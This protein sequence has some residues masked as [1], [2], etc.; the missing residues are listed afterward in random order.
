MNENTLAIIVA[1]GRSSRLSGDGGLSRADRDIPKQY[2]LLAGRSV[3]DRTVEKFACHS[4]IDNILVV[5]HR[6]DVDAYQKLVSTHD[7]LLLSVT[8]GDSR[9]QSVHNGLIAAHKIGFGGKIL[10]HDAARPFVESDVITQVLDNIAPAI[11]AIAAHRVVDTLKRGDSRLEVSSTVARDDL[12]CAQTP[13]GFMAKDIIAVHDNASKNG[14]TDFTDDASMFEAAGLAVRIINASSLNFKIT[15]PDD[16]VRAR[17]LVEKLEGPTVTHADIRTGN[18]YDVHAFSPGDGVILCGYKIPFDKKLSGHSD[19]DVALHALT[20]AL[21]GTIGAGDIG[22]HFPPSEHRWKDASSDLFLKYALKLVA[23]EGGVINNVDITLI[24]EAPKIG[25]H[26]EKMRVKLAELCALE[27]ARVSVKATTNEK[28]G[29]LGREEGIA[30]IATV[31]I[32]FGA[33]S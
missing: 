11:G 2:M 24:C 1:G 33:R 20:D 30:A 14:T 27:L 18:G 19:A 32:S 28:L 29:F 8:G 5:I 15:T 3:L 26:R 22:T 17:S 23:N 13:Q 25:P 21:L 4:Q 16:L 9:Q 7:K 12:F 31:A 10:I 6:N